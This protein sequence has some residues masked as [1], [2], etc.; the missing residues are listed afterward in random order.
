VEYSS[1]AR[2]R[3]LLNKDIGGPVLRQ[4]STKIDLHQVRILD[5]E[6]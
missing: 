2:H 3:K 6:K 4:K 5:D 1:A